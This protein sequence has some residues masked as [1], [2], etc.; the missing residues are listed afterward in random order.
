[1]CVVSVCC[2]FI[3]EWI[4]ASNGGAVVVPTFLL[5]NAFEAPALVGNMEVRAVS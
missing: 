5:R 3:D 2:S 4:D 1:M